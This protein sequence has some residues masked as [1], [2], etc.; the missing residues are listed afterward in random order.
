M[1]ELDLWNL[2]KESNKAERS[3]MF[4]LGAG[5]VRP[6]PLETGL[7]A[8]YVCHDRRFGGK[9]DFD[10]L[11]FT[12]SHASPLIVQSSYDSNKIYNYQF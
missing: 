7:G 1:S 2:N 3:D 6:E 9:I 11:H 8:G 4:G 12:N 5:H 10:V